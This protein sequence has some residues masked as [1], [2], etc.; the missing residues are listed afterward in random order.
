[1]EIRDVIHGN[2][3]VSSS[4]AKIIDSPFFQRLRNI[5]QLGF[6]ENSYPGATHNR[7]IH[8]LGA[9]HLAGLAFKNAFRGKDHPLAQQ[10]KVAERF[11]MALRIATMLHDIGHGPLSHTTEF[12]MPGI[13]KLE[14]RSLACIPG[15]PCPF[16]GNRRAN[17]ED[18][19][20]KI[21]LQ[22][23]LTPL[24][25]KTLSRW[26]IDPIHVACIIN[27]DIVCPD[28]FFIVDGKDG[29]VDYRPILH[30]IVS[31]EMDVDRMD[32][33]TRDSFH[34]GVNYGKFDVSWV[35]SNLTHH[36]FRGK[37]YLALQHKAIYTFDDFLISRF[38][39]FLMVYFHHKSV[40]FDEMLGRYLRS[41]DC[42]YEIPS[43]VESYV[44]YDDYH[45]YTHL[46][47]S[48]N[49]WAKRIYHK[50]PYKM[51][52]EFH[53][54]IPQGSENAREQKA[55]LE[56]VTA[57]LAAKGVDYIVKT[58]TSEFSKYFKK[59]DRMPIF[60][61]YDNKVLPEKFIPLEECTDLFE[62]YSKN[63]SITRVYVPEIP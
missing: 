37:C 2:I 63:R 30:Q 9:T 17:H 55:H 49:S 35:L 51:L 13:E 60:V 28:D 21:I 23:S 56:K 57:E 19:T 3:E 24:L 52:V 59:D 54:G 50:N 4:E 25:K 36:I 6:A 33:L 15:K 47:R 34:A 46:S 32:Y 61:R 10:P 8:S 62:R 20:I 31:S 44:F 12:A 38:H 27:E 39:M 16:D 26:D 41:S 22:S 5:K 14:L 43:D 1:M 58:T 42:D 48:K 18:Y 29:K 11:R 40:I 53:S 45:L 7:Y